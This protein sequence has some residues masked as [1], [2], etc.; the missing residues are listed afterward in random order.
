LRHIQP[1]RPT[2]NAHVESLHARLRDECLRINWFLNLFDARRK[3]ADW[4][5]EY[6][7]ER[8]H[9]SLG[10]CTPMEFAQKKQIMSYGVNSYH[11][12]CEL[13]GQTSA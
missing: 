5:V 13:S 3:I 12:V 9:S 6:N 10:Y 2:Q 11:C 1:G 8:P 7:Q 4:K